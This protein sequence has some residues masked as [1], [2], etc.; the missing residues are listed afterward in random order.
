MH[1]RLLLMLAFGWLVVVAVIL[2]STW[3]SGQALIRE[4]ANEHLEYEARMIAGEIDQEV[5]LRFD[6]LQRLASQLGVPG[7]RASMALSSELK[8]NDALLSLF[9]GLVVISSEG[10][11]LADWPK[12]DGREGLSVLESEYFQFQRHVARPYVSEPF[13]GRAS[14]TPLILFSVPLLDDNGRFAGVI[15]GVANV[16][17]GSFFDKLRRI[18]IGKQGYAAIMTASGKVLVHPDQDLIM[19]PV[20]VFHQ[21]P[22]LDLA[23]SGWQGLA[24]APLLTGQQALQAYRQIWSA[25]WIVGIMLPQTQAFQPLQWFVR[26]LWVV[27]TLTGAV[28]L[29]LLWWLLR[30]ALIPLQRLERQIASVGQGRYERIKLDTHAI[31]IRRVADT[32]NQVLEKQ[33]RAEST[34]LD[35]QAFL[36]AVLRSSPVGMFV[37]GLE[38]GLRYA[39]PALCRMTGYDFKVLQQQGYTAYVHADD[40]Q[41]VSDHWQHTLATGRDFQRQYRY[42][43]ASGET[44]WV[45]SH[46]SLVRLR[47]KRP[48]GYVGTFKDI[49]HTREMEA[50]QRWEA[51][52][53][54]LTGLLNRRG[55]ERR[56]EE[57]LIDRLKKGTPS[58]LILFDLDHF[59]P[60]ND[61]GGHALGD[62][63]LKHIA[64]LIVSKVRKSDAVSRYGGDEFALL[65][66]GCDLD[67]ARKMAE[68]LRES[69][70]ALSIEH[71]KKRYK[72]TLSIGVTVLREGDDQI[73]IPMQRADQAS[74]QAKAR[75]RNAIMADEN[76]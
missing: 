37:Y 26:N 36:D 61:E 14:K 13:Q 73:N 27:G 69:V 23:L 56:L 72:V 10:R 43:K 59:K 5:Q 24:S 11:V 53:D 68:T 46:I 28:T 47:D 33:R 18:R 76:M 38:G 50:L 8:R 12:V 39:N 60:I 63:M 66:P 34:M 7:S 58:A 48:L 35:R 21:N 20:P 2:T 57:S 16:L 44:I 25:N 70:E 49:T 19:Q 41:D 1:K 75:G 67:H 74:Y 6:A 40:Q 32:F 51:E 29:V 45:E 52:H 54:P 42:I 17:N 3:H 64:A 71:D 55:F 9:D 30:L 22:W 65:L 15:S 62:A 4:V 31:E